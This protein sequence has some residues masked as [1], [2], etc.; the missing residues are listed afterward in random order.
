MRILKTFCILFVTILCSCKSKPKIDNE[1]AIQLINKGLNLPIVNYGT[2]FS[3]DKTIGDG[4][5]NDG[6]YIDPKRY[7]RDYY[8]GNALSFLGEIDLLD[9]GYREITGRIETQYM[10]PNNYG[11]P[12]NIDIGG[13]LILNFHFTKKA[14]PY[15]QNTPENMNIWNTFNGVGT[16]LI[17]LK[18]NEISFGNIISLRQV[19]DN[20]YEVE[21]S[22]NVDNTP[23][24]EALKQNKRAWNKSGEFIEPRQFETLKV[25]ILKYEDGWNIATED[26]ARLRGQL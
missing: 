16:A 24:A 11:L 4:Y 22:L 5:K 14:E 2:F 12:E 19:N 9:N 3:G 25:K 18:T 21:F 7:L 15:L 26:L 8:S 13:P 6:G 1:A 10:G 23:F 17:Q 20:E